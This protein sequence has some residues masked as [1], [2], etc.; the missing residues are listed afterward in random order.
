MVGPLDFTDRSYDKA[1]GNKNW[2]LDL[3]SSPLALCS[4][5]ATLSAGVGELG[6]IRSLRFSIKIKTGVGGVMQRS[7]GRRHKMLTS[8]ALYGWAGGWEERKKMRPREES[9]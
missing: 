3:G 1:T 9:G 7:K 2:L 6:T 5:Q 8:S 4:P